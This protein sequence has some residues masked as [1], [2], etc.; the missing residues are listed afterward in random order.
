[1]LKKLLVLLVLPFLLIPFLCGCQEKSDKTV[2]TF[3]SWGSLTETQI[4]ENVIKNYENDNPNIKIN[5]LHV[6]QNYFQKIHLLFAS[7][8]APDVIF[9][10]NLYLPVYASK[11]L[12]LSDWQ[13]LDDFYPESIKAMSYENKVLAIPRDVSTLVFYRNKALIPQKPQNLE[14]LIISISK[15]KYFG[16]S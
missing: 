3:S 15:S 9:I 8:Q 10:N 1:M 2:L 11:L 13:N 6:P 4:L 16:I 7:N 12:D 5:F 14:E